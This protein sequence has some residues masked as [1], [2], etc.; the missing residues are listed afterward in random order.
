MSISRMLPPPALPRALRARSTS[1][2]T[3]A[4]SGLTGSA[5]VS[6]R[7][8]SSRSETRPFM[9]S[10][11]SRMIRTNWRTTAGSRSAT[12]SRIVDAD[13]LME[14]RGI[15]SS[16]L[17]MARKSARSRSVSS[18]AARSWRVT[19][20]DST[21][22]SSP[23]MGAALSSTVTLLPVGDPQHDLLGLDR[24]RGAQ[25]PGQGKLPAATPPA[26][27]PAGRS[28]GSAGPPASGRGPA[29]CPRCA[30]PPG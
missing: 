4:G 23:R 19:M 12:E 3:S 1:A 10:A 17:T 29:G 14:V 27:R 30:W 11:W 16:W 9:W 21:A 15:L 25:Q 5:P 8:T 13:P 28:L 20:K 18:T 26:R 22:P 2:A 24:L 7:A 6:M